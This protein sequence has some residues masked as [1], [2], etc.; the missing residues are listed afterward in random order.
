MV[1]TRIAGLAAQQLRS[2]GSRILRILRALFLQ[3]VGFVFLA[4]AAWG[5]L[6]LVRVWREFQT[7][8]EGVLKVALVGGF[9][10]M[11]GSFGIS[12]FWR[13]RRISRFK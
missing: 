3:V 5:A 1:D 10:F 6:G 11:M 9:V 2:T 8:G 4:L 12:S 13:A 7:G